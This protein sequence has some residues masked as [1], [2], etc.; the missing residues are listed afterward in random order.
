MQHKYVVFDNDF[1]VCFGGGMI[2]AALKYK[3]GFDR[4]EPTSA[5]FFRLAAD[6]S[7]DI[8]V[9]VYG[10]SISLRLQSSPGDADK[11]ALAL[12]IGD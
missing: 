11:I 8:S 10:E 4:M 2:H 3:D 6:H 1:A 5:G 12:G 7:G 9:H